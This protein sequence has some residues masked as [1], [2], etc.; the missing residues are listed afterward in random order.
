MEAAPALTG[1]FPRKIILPLPVTILLLPLA[2]LLIPLAEE[3]PG[4]LTPPFL[5]A[6]LSKNHTGN[7]SGCYYT[8]SN[9][10]WASGKDIN[11]RKDLDF[12]VF[13]FSKEKRMARYSKYSRCQTGGRSNKI[14]LGV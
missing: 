12:Y 7:T 8:K 11:T 14:N 13:K 6:Y 1:S 10:P 3:S 9:M 5:N 2:D 4:M